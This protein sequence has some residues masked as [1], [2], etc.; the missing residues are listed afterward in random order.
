MREAA[1]SPPARVRVAELSDFR[2]PESKGA[3]PRRRRRHHRT[4]YSRSVDWE[5]QPRLEPH[6]SGVATG[7]GARGQAR[8]TSPPITPAK[9][10]HQV[11]TFTLLSTDDIAQV[12][13]DLTSS[14]WMRTPPRK[15]S[16]PPRAGRQCDAAAS[17]P[18]PRAVG[19]RRKG[20]VA[21]CAARTAESSP[22][23]R[24]GGPAAGTGMP[25]PGGG[26]P[27]TATRLTQS[28]DWESNE[29][30]RARKFGRAV[31]P[32]DAST[33]LQEIAGTTRELGSEDFS[34]GK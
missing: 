12:R 7:R 2:R 18:P 27:V 32:S 10:P 30:V 31:S 11:E 25:R 24:L 3:S 8:S 22:Q 4:V 15:A 34:S 9:E 26:S 29:D 14:T 1:R 6:G 20:W 23:P 5:R 33:V 28:C 21:C 19:G 13:Q 17:K 16:T